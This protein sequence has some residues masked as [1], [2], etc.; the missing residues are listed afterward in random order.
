MA[1]FDMSFDSWR[2]PARLASVF[3]LETVSET[4][5]ISHFAR[6]ESTHGARDYLIYDFI[7][8]FITLAMRASTRAHVAIAAL[9]HVAL[10]S[11]EAW[12]TSHR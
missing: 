8:L 6:V 12:R 1:P 7:T 11:I 9:F 10:V 5:K 2:E 4:D 3:R